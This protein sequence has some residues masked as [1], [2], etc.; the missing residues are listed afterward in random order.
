MQLNIEI[1]PVDLEIN[2]VSYPV[3]EKT[4]D[5]ARKIADILT[6][7]DRNEK[8]QYVMWLE[9]LRL[10]L[11]EA[12]VEE[13]FP[14]EHIG[15]INLDFLEAVYSSAMEAFDYNGRELRSKQDKA[16]L[17]YLHDLANT[18]ITISDKVQQIYGKYPGIGR[19]Q[20]AE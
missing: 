14:A 7:E 2:G 9:Q 18:L 11:G 17:D 4:V 8:L 12:A 1:R 16:E 19:P 15:E 6:S 10:V 13:L 5:V 20:A 3:V